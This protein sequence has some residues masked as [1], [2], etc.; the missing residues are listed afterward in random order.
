[1]AEEKQ[2]FVLGVD[3]DGVCADFIGGL[4]PI[5]AEWL[6]VKEEALNSEPTYGFP[7]WELEKIGGDDAYNKLH[8]YAITQRDMFSN[9]LAI[10]DAPV[11]LRRLAYVYKVR[12]RIITHRLFVPHFH[13]TAIRQTVAWLDRQGIPYYDLCFMKEK[14]AVG[15]DLYIEDSPSNVEALRGDGHETIVFANSTNKGLPDPRTN[16]WQE[17]E[18]LVLAAMERWK[19]R[20]GEKHKSAGV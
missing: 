12:I 18:R 17:V 19:T 11:V 15:A 1:M 20:G 3:L 5:A 14:A 10:K 16:D 2:R 4:R 13:E 8:L 6:G 9:L 7:E